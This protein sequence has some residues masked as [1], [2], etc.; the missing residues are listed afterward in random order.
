MTGIRKLFIL[1]EI[2][3]KLTGSATFSLIR[4]PPSGPTEFLYIDPVG[5]VLTQS[6]KDTS[7]DTI[8]LLIDH[9]IQVP[10][11]FTDRVI[12]RRWTKKRT[13]RLMLPAQ[14]SSTSYLPTT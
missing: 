5:I 11:R 1:S 3:P 7:A 9:N 6:I 4:P 13:H 10:A 2:I 14:L 12:R 8:A